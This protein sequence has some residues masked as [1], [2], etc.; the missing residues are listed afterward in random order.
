LTKIY[1]VWYKDVQSNEKMEEFDWDEANRLKNWLKHS[2]STKEAEQVFLNKKSIT[3]EDKVHS[4][5][6]IR[7]KILGITKKNRK[8]HIT[9]TIRNNK[10]RIISARDQ[11]KK[12]RKLYEKVK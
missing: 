3:L 9:F 8:L 12:E 7:Y 5:I 2:V 6:E 1:F 4:Q 11:S 10:I